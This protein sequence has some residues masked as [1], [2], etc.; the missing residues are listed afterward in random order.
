MAKKNK[1][2]NLLSEQD[3][4]LIK[5][6]AFE[7]GKKSLND[8]QLKM[9]EELG[10]SNFDELFGALAL[11]GINMDKLMDALEN[12]EDVPE[13]DEEFRKKFYDGKGTLWNDVADYNDD[14][15][16]YDEDFYYDED[17]DE[18]ITCVLHDV[19][20]KELHLRVKLNDAPVKIWREMKVPSN[21]SLEAFANLLQDIMGWTHEHLYHF[22]QKDV[23]Y[24]SPSDLNHEQENHAFP[25]RFIRHDANKF[26]LGNVFREKG[27]RI[28]FEYDLGDSWFHDIWLKGIREYEPGETPKA[29]LLKGQGACPPENCGGVWGYTH[30]LDLVKK[31]RKTKD[32]KAHLEWAGID[33]NYDPEEYDLEE[34]RSY[35]AESWEM[36][37]RQDRFLKLDD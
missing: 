14:D 33:K 6:K 10:I 13:N 7:E 30:L 9:M 25:L 28:V 29:M 27:D 15:H 3:L 37:M 31:K 32:E 24:A 35:I 23:R 22:I 4:D 36:L 11:S 26:H 17:F 20:A 19:E 18:D 34:E 12:K 5:Q 16:A 1:D 2:K 21:L 8:V